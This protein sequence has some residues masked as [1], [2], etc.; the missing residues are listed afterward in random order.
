M[1]VPPDLARELGAVWDMFRV[2]FGAALAA[3]ESRRD[4]ALAGY[5]EAVRL[6]RQLGLPT[7]TAEFLLDAVYVLRPEDPE[8]PGLADE[9]RAVHGGRRPRA[10]RP[11]RPG[12]RDDIAAGVRQGGRHTR[13]RRCDDRG[14][15]PLARGA[16]AAPWAPI[17]GHVLHRLA[18][19]ID[20]KLSEAP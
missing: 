15:G 12:P 14:N 9:A 7:P 16:A 11:A 3:L 1:T 5:P 17:D 19:A 13:R 18:R 20:R 2:G 10:A 6:A 4:E 8:T